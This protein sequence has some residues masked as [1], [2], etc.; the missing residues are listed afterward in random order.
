MKDI[1]KTVAV[2][3]AVAGVLALGLS[4]VSKNVFAANEGME[5]CAGIV[6]AGLNDCGTSKHDCAGKAMTDGDPE[7]WLYLPQGTCNKI[8]NGT[9]KSN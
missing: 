2:A 4:T 9:L 1:K 8:V 3:A 6:K 7:E 5:K